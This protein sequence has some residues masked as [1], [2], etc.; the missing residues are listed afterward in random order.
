MFHEADMLEDARGLF[1]AH[2]HHAAVSLLETAPV[3]SGEIAFW[4][5]SA[6]IGLHDVKRA[7]VVLRDALARGERGVLGVLAVTGRLRGE[8][9]T[10]LET[11]T[12]QDCAS[13]DMFA[14]ALLEREVGAWHLECERFE[15]ALVWLERAWHTA[16]VGPYGDQ[17]LPGIATPL[18][19]AL[20]RLG[21]D[22]RAVMVLDEGV[23]RCDRTRRV[24][25]L[26]ERALRNVHLGR[27]EAAHTDLAEL[28]MH[29][30]RG[31]A[32]LPLLVAYARARYTHALGRSA[33]ARR[34][35][36]HVHATA[37]PTADVRPA[38]RELALHSALWL[39]ALC[40]EAD[41]L[42]AA[43]P[44]LDRAAAHATGVRDHAWLTLRRAQACA[45]AGNHAE[46][47]A[48]FA[49]AARSFVDLNARVECAGAHVHR[50]DALLHLGFEREDEAGSV[51]LEAVERIQEI[52][53][54]A[55]LRLELRALPRVRAYLEQPYASN[56]VRALLAPSHTYR[57]VRVF[58]DRLEAD[59]ERLPVSDTGAR[60]IAY[61]RAH[62]CST[63][64]HLRDAVYADMNAN[65]ARLAFERDR[66]LASSVPGLE[67]L[68]VGATHS[69]SLA[70]TAV[71]LEI[72]HADTGMRLP[73]L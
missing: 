65:S 54:A 30:P 17:Q 46:A 52:G 64:A 6:L 60:L 58:A 2:E 63:W 1:F 50:A 43:H 24:P 29:V 49:R 9:R 23:R 3:R 69:Y 68:Y 59:G 33:E 37:A 62:P 51:L 5:A 18:A 67:I 66:A 26:Y 53:G 73:T 11:L 39:A 55:G 8:S 10:Y 41:D 45:T 14:R 21:F 56:A 16:L 7:E 71:S 15:D 4:L 13:H 48:G 70:W 22:A 42:D 27:L 35:F 12:P 25:L 44:W 72:A 57:S 20:A 28:D 31:D 19:A 40:L 61:L 36:E 34:W 38:V 32:E 47:V